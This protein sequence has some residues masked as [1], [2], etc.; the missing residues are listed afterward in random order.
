MKATSRIMVALILAASGACNDTEDAGPQIPDLGGKPTFAVALSD[1]ESAGVAL[2]DGDGKVLSKKYIS[3]GSAVPG[4]SSALHGDIGLPTR[5]CEAGLLTLVARYGGDYVLQVDLS[6][7]KAV[8][9]IATQGMSGGAAYSGNPQDILCLGDGQAL[10]SRF[11]PSVQAG[12]DALDQGDD[13]LRIDL[14]KEK[15]LSRVDLS[16]LRGKL[17][18]DT[19]YAR[20]GSIVRVGRHALVGLS[21][22]TASFAAGEG[23]VAIVDLADGKVRGLD[24]PKLN[25]CGILTPVA[26][27]DDAVIVSCSGY[28]FGDRASSGLLL[29]SLDEQ[30][31]AEIEHSFQ[32]SKAQPPIYAYPVSLGGTRVAAVATGDF[33]KMT[34]DISYVVDLATAD[35]SELFMS[36]SAGEIGRGAFRIDTGLLLIP[37]AGEG[38]RTFMVGADEVTAK[39]TLALDPALPPRSIG[40]LLDL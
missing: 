22:L 11:E 6:D 30:G 31:E 5:A 18:G 38:V 32:S 29:V 10:V 23:M 8:H 13:I 12:A 7:G 33:T 14:D 19:V 3:S 25:N 40:P 2:I 27:R 15:R 4:L 9:Q 36:S 1:Y 35:A 24:L 37:D 26:G 39:K 34:P 21:R 28:P 17:G 16:K 20:P